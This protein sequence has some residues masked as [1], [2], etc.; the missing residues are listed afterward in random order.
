MYFFTRCGC[1]DGLYRKDMI[2]HAM[3]AGSSKR[4]NTETNKLMFV[5]INTNDANCP[6]FLTPEKNLKLS[7]LPLRDTRLSQ[8]WFVFKIRWH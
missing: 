7:T 3:M 6:L 2:R 5:E 4:K 1:F 8:T